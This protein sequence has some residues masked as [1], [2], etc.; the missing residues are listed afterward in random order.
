M[1]GRRVLKFKLYWYKNLFI[2][3]VVVC[4]ET[5]S[6]GYKVSGE[7]FKNFNAWSF[8]FPLVVVLTFSLCLHK[9]HFIF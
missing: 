2:N 1:D 6:E 9:V 4:L 3:I 5:M 8:T 7:P